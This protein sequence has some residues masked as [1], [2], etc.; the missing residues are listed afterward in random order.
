M[1]MFQKRQQPNLITVTLPKRQWSIHLE[2]RRH[3]EGNLTVQPVQDVT[4]VPTPQLG[5]DVET[6][7]PMTAPNIDNKMPES[8]MKPVSQNE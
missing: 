8:T 2:N 6:T 3:I 4:E 7:E 1:T 5:N